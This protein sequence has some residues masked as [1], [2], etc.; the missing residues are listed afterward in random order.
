VANAE[1]RGWRRKNRPRG[2]GGGRAS[3]GTSAQSGSYK[4]T[5]RRYLKGGHPCWRSSQGKRT[6]GEEEGEKGEEED[7]RTGGG[8]GE[9]RWP[10]REQTRDSPLG[11]AQERILPRGSFTVTGRA[12]REEGRKGRSEYAFREKSR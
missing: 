3:G 6:G 4:R 10:K 2:R 8:G 11:S 1:G 7:G 12:E 5:P 9:E